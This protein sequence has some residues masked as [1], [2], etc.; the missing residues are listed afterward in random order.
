MG[1]IQVDDTLHWERRRGV[2]AAERCGKDKRLLMGGGRTKEGPKM[3]QTRLI[4]VGREG[5]IDIF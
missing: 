5:G 1:N 2:G 3:I 4:Q